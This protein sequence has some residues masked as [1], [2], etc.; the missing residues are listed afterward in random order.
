MDQTRQHPLR[1]L[2][3]RQNFSIQDLAEAT[4]LSKRTIL[5]AEQGYSL[6]PESRRIL[7]N[8]FG[9]SPQEL[10]LLPSISEG[11]S[12]QIVLYVPGS[13][14][15][16]DHLDILQKPGF[17][18]EVEKYMTHE[19]ISRRTLL[20]KLLSLVSLT[21]PTLSLTGD[22]L[23]PEAD[24]RLSK[25]IHDPTALNEATITHYE[26]LT[27]LCWQLS[28][29]DGLG[30]IEQLLPSYLPALS[31]LAKQQG[32]YQIRMASIAAQSYL[33]SYVIALHREDFQRALSYCQ[34]ARSFGQLARDPNL[35]VIS[36]LRQGNVYLYLH[37]PWRTLESYQE[38]LPQVSDISPLVQTRLYAVMAEVQG[39]LG[40]EADVRVSMGAA[41]NVFPSDTKNDPAAQY[42]HFSQSGLY[43]HEGLAF[44]NLHQGKQ[45]AV[46]LEQVNGLSP[47]LP[48]SERSRI[49]ILV[50]QSWAASQ[51]GDL[52]MFCTHID[53]AIASA[54]RLG[55][56]LLLSEAW[57]CY[58]RQGQ[59]KDEQQFKGL[60]EH[61]NQKQRGNA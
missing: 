54:R 41:Y 40:T 27:S 60:G 30:L 38:A 10:G 50:Q 25:A 16:H 44:L 3:E 24:Q 1:T 23:F 4:S 59:W 9:K 5:R 28:E 14:S 47:K 58:S 53:A 36:L 43:L 57:E 6:H 2:R 18:R 29:R 45:A 13:S 21:I 42:I 31:T 32:K 51:I 15:E 20:Q 22:L 56:D 12:E 46:V 55:S 35:E 37:S 26:Q 33:L 48:I 34:Q 7:C 19:D 17:L 61:F 11:R 8:Y 39:K 52:D 49:D